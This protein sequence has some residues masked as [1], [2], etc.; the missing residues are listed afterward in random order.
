MDSAQHRL[1]RT[2]AFTPEKYPRPSGAMQL[3]LTLFMGQVIFLNTIYVVITTQRQR[4]SSR[5][6][7]SGET[8][9]AI[10]SWGPTGCQAPREHTADVA[11]F[12]SHL[13]QQGRMLSHVTLLR[14]TR[15]VKGL[16]RGSHCQCKAPWPPTST[17][18]WLLEN[19]DL[20]LWGMAH[21]LRFLALKPAQRSPSPW[22]LLWTL[23]IQT[24]KPSPHFSQSWSSLCCSH[25]M[26]WLF[27]FDVDGLYNL[28]R[29]R[30]SVLFFHQRNTGAQTVLSYRTFCKNK[31]AL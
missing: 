2:K 17:P 29:A 14:G 16:W 25:H 18:V 31:N 13:E 23:C 19:P 12:D 21:G 4:K 22:G 27:V 5:G 15:P 8:R 7:N 28:H 26:I 6:S 3:K 20:V 1:F 30:I 11:S 9:A 24:C 10:T